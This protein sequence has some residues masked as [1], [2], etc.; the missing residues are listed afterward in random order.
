MCYGKRKSPTAKLNSLPV[1]R[2][3]LSETKFCQTGAEFATS[4]LLDI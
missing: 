4:N 2:D 1:R 3:K